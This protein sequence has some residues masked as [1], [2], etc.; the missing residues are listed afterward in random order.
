MNSYSKIKC[1][2]FDLDGTIIN[3]SELIYYS[4]KS[5]VKHNTGI[6]LRRSN[7]KSWATINPKSVLK[8]YGINDMDEYWLHYLNNISTAELFFNDTQDIL[9]MLSEKGSILGIVSSLPKSKITELLNYFYLTN[10]F[11]VIIG[12]ERSMPKKPNPNSIQTALKKLNILPENAA[13]I[14]D[15]NID[16]E[17]AQR[18]EVASVY[19]SWSRS[20]IKSEFKPDFI[21][22]N[23][24]DLTSIFKY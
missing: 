18:A 4:L 1:L 2:L 20:E 5:T 19:V 17:A 21:I 6:V 23:L 16:I 11:E 13:Y 14:G 22:H 9:Q 10:C 8:E 24:K 15:R 12:W 7:L 3:T